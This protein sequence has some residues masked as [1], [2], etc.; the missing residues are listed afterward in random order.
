MISTSLMKY[1]NPLT[2]TLN[3][4]S[5]VQERLEVLSINWWRPIVNV[6]RGL[7]RLLGRAQGVFGGAIASHV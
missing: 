6:E 1:S 7:N 2:G 3:N 5:V 4:P